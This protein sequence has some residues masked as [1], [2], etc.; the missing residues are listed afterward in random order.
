ML[1]VKNLKN[2]ESILL[3]QEGAIL[4]SVDQELIKVL[5]N[6]EDKT[7]EATKKRKI[8]IILEIEPSVMRD[9]FNLNA[10]IS[11][12]LAPKSA[13]QLSLDLKSSEDGDYI[14]KEQKDEA[15]GQQD[16]FGNEET[17]LALLLLHPKLIDDNHHSA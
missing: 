17:S 13:M 6:I 4:K 5:D 9:S 7:T 1:F 11:S 12:T 8:S 14:I 15:E 2:A 16:I 3:L 10:A